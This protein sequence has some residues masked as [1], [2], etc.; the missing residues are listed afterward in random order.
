M[1]A[2]LLTWRQQAREARR[3]AARKAQLSEAAAEEAATELR[4]SPYRRI[5]EP[6]LRAANVYGTWA[7]P[8]GGAALAAFIA[9]LLARPGS[10]VP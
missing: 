7:V 9:A 4:C 6:A 5:C 10:G 2:T 3:L 1:L 8:V